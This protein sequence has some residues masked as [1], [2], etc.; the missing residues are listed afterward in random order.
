MNILESRKLFN[1]RFKDGQNKI[2][3]LT[4]LLH[5]AWFTLCRNV[6]SQKN[7]PWLYEN[8]QAVHEVPLHGLKMH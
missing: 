8:H 7:R 6:N 4:F 3:T 2:L 5:E 1:Y